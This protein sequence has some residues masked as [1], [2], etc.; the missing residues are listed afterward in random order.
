M[1]EVALV[2]AGDK[3]DPNV[4]VKQI[5]A[6][7]HEYCT[8]FR[9]TVF[10]DQDIGLP[11][12]R[13]IPLPDWNLSARQLWWYKLY[14]HAEHTWTGPILYLDL[15]TIIVNSIDKFWDWEPGKYAICQDFN[16]QFIETYPVSNSS[17]MRFDPGSTRDM[18]SHFISDI[19]KHLRQFRGD[20]DYV[21]DWFK[22][23]PG[24]SWWPREWAMSY[25]WEIKHGGTRVG[26]LDVKYPDDY[27]QPDQEEVVPDACSIVVFHGKPDPY[28][29]FFGKKR[30]TT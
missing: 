18:Y 27:L 12:V 26:G 9:L 25:K 4:H 19:P 21:T 6:N 22:H 23:R 11:G 30:L 3:F 1:K 5:Y 13:T 15:D 28:D 10:T 20:Q 17:V 7:L 29:T 14:I 16:R 2:C 24:K 8:D